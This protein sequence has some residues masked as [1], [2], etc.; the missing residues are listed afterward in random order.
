MKKLKTRELTFT[1]NVPWTK[2][3]DSK[4]MQAV[5]L[6]KGNWN[7]ITKTIGSKLVEDCKQRI[8]KL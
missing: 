4:L 1:K 3:E 5:Q 7:K 2:E 6:F 8:K